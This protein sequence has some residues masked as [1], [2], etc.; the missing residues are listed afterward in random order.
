MAA[1]QQMTFKAIMDMKEEAFFDFCEKRGIMAE[2][3][4]IAGRYTEQKVYPKMRRWNEE[5]EKYTYVADKSKAPKIKSKPITFFEV[6]AAVCN[7]VLK[8]EKKKPAKK[9]TFRER[10]AERAQNA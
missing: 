10:A 6:K 3:N 8:I 2:V 1:K 9:T 7:E 4:E 5:K